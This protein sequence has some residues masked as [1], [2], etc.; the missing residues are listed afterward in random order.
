MVSLDE[1]RLDRE[2]REAVAADRARLITARDCFTSG[3]NVCTYNDKYQRIDVEIECETHWDA[4]L[5]LLAMSK[6]A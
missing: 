1:I 5:V 6:R 3:K 4:V 2:R